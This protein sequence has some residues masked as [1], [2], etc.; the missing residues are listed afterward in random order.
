[1]TRSADLR[2]ARRGRP[3]GLV[4]RRRR[5]LPVA[6]RRP[7]SGRSPSPGYLGVGAAADVVQGGA[8]DPEPAAEPAGRGRALGVVHPRV[9]QACSTRTGPES[10][11]ARRRSRRPAVRADRGP[12]RRSGC[13]LRPPAHRDPHAGVHRRARSTWPSPCCG[14]CSRA[15]AFLVLSAWCLGHPQQPP[16]V[17][18]L[19]RG[20]GAVERRP[21][22]ARGDRGARRAPPRR[23][24]PPRSRGA[25]WSAACSS[26]SSSCPTVRSLVPDL[27]AVARP[28]V[29]RRARA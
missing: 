16:P 2:A 14:S 1:M 20:A 12:R 24:S 21:D 27:R 6:D 18:P 11:T 23:A 29:A 26:S 13:S 28:R 15:S 9:R 17:L 22:R 19:L 25:S 7:R 8:A 3:A 4:P 5:D 10:R